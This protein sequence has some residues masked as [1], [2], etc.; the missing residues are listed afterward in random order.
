MKSQQEMSWCWRI[1]R[2]RSDAATR[3]YSSG[4]KRLAD[5][6]GFLTRQEQTEEP[7]EVPSLL[8]KGGLLDNEIGVV[9]K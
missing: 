4:G 3:L 5:G 6:G 8:R 9:R 7:V 1:S 2:D